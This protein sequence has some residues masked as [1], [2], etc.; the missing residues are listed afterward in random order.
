MSV[1]G[2]F[3]SS[4]WCLEGDHPTNGALFK[5]LDSSDLEH[6]EFQNSNS[7]LYDVI[8]LD[9]IKARIQ[10]SGKRST[11]YYDNSANI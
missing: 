1:L 7:N 4:Y 10:A 5:V 2:D 8:P 3:S 11:S 6:F 9:R